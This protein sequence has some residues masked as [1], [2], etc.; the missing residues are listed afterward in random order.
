MRCPSR[1]SVVECHVELLDVA[2]D[3]FRAI[4][5][6]ETG[7]VRASALLLALEIAASS[8]RQQQQVVPMGAA[9]GVTST[10]SSTA[11]LAALKTFVMPSQP[12]GAEASVSGSDSSNANSTAAVAGELFSDRTLRLNDMYDAV[13]HLVFQP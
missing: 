11:L 10:S 2:E 7:E 1:N 12:L 5:K 9:N 4:D 13:F 3:L 6:G 8:T